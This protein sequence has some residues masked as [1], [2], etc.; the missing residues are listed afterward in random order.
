MPALSG[1]YDPGV[2]IISLTF[3]ASSSSSFLVFNMIFAFGS[4]IAFYLK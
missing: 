3:Y 4:C 2:P 1:M